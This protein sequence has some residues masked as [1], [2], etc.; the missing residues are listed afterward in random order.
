MTINEAKQLL[1][2]AQ[3]IAVL[4]GADMAMESG[5]TDFRSNEGLYNPLTADMT[6]HVKMFRTYPERFYS[7]IK[8]FYEQCVNG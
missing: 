8:P 3:K 2:K 4:T 5:V 1:A 7:T 6:F